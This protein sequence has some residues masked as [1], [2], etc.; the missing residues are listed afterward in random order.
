MS[1]SLSFEHCRH[2]VFNHDRDN[3]PGPSDLSS[4][5]HCPCSIRL[6]YIVSVILFCVLLAWNLWAIILAISE[7]NSVCPWFNAVFWRGFISW[8]YR[9]TQLGFQ[10][11]KCQFQ[12]SW[13]SATVGMDYELP[14]SRAPSKN[15]TSSTSLRCGAPAEDSSES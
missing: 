10:S 2:D 12:T 9:L 1:Y 14:L 13:A 7:D 4:R 3:T 11:E 5:F 8:V 15:S 6:G